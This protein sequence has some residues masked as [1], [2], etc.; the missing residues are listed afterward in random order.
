MPEKFNYSSLLVISI[1][2]FI[3]PFLVMKLKRLKIPFQVGEI[4][5]GVIVGK[6]CLNLVHSD[7]SILFLSNLGLAYLMFLIGLEIN[8]DDLKPSKGGS[9]IIKLPIIMLIVSFITAL[10]LA[11]F[12]RNLIGITHGYTLFAFIFMA[13]AAGLVSPILKSKNIISSEL[14]QIV[15]TFSIICQFTSILGTTV[16]FSISENGLTFKSFEFILIFLFAAIA[17]FV[18]KIFLKRHDLTIP[19]FKNIHLMVRAAFVLMLILVVIAEQL[20]TEIILGAFLAGMIFSLLTGKAKEEISHQLNIIG[21]GFLIPIFFIMIGVKVDLK[22]VLQDPSII[23]K[24]IVLLII[25][26]IVKL[27]PSLLLR[28]KFG[29]KKAISSSVLLSAQLSIVIVSAELALKFGFITAPDYSAFI[30]T[31]IAS[32]IIFPIIFEKLMPTEDVQAVPASSDILVREIILNN[33]D[34]ENKPLKDC[35]FKSHCRIFS[36]IRDDI[37]VIPNGDSILYKGDI[38]VL[39][40]STSD[41]ELTV[42]ILGK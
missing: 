29:M 13:A 35:H 26:F 1:I 19:S 9:T 2:A 30:I 12:G 6:T 39:V 7:V 17:Y 23:L 41:V 27:I 16:I 24:A 21:Y 3:T 40:G 14:G 20:N 4:I 31:T 25:F 34:Y 42:D 5:I 32:C 11:Y 28:K 37:E 18:S 8:F 36:Y 22:I 10:A 15:L 38:L 33:E